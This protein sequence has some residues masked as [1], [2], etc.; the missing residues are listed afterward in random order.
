MRKLLKLWRALEG[1][2]GLIGVPEIWRQECGEDFEFAAPHLKPTDMIGKRY[3]CPNSF[4]ECPRRIIDYSDDEFAAIC[5]DE[6][7]R[8]ERVP[9]TRREA[10]IHRLDLS[11]LLQPVLRAAMIRPQAMTLHSPGLW[12]VG[13]SEQPH[14]RNYPVYFLLAHSQSSHEA[15]VGRLLLDIPDSF[16]LV[17][18]TNRFRTVETERRLRERR[19]EC[20]CLEEQVFVDG[21][22]K[23]QWTGAVETRRA[24]RDQGPVPRSVGSPEAVAAVKEYILARGLSQTE[25]SIQAGVSERTLRNFLKDGTMRRSALEGVANAMNLSLEQLLRGELPASLKLP[26][27]R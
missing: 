18:P 17:L 12:A 8:C 16:L 10:L 4:S 24:A 14:V 11:G 25:F 7:Q 9:L 6:H 3:P 22:G 26:R 13:L 27:R 5:Q 1:I 23:F 15:A 2:P 20:L 21:Q 19:V